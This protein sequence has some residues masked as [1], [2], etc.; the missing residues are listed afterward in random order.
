MEDDALAVTGR[1]AR[2]DPLEWAAQ[3]IGALSRGRV[4]D[5][6]C[7]DGRFLPPDGVG[8]DVDAARLR[9]AARRSARVAVADAHALPFPDATFD[10]ALANRMLNDAGAI[11]G[12]LAE[13]GRVLRPGGRLLVLTLARPDRSVLRGV[14]DEARAALG[15]GRARRDRV[16]RLDDANGEA[17]LRLHFGRVDVERFLRRHRFADASAALDHYARRYLGSG[18]DRAET[19]ALFERVRSALLA[20][21]L[22]IEEEDR[23]ALFVAER[24]APR[25]RRPSPPRP[26][27]RSPSR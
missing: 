19:A 5:V 15:I 21:P 9:L 3:R 13:I 12:V 25:S 11:D 16:D 7:G 6:G 10:T 23:A 2:D 27:R 26:R 1:R 24:R 20:L 18:H 4:L 8:I 14:H 22:P 17:R